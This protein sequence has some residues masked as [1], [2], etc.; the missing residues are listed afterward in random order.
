MSIIFFYSKGED[1]QWTI[2]LPLMYW[3]LRSGNILETLTREAHLSHLISS[4]LISL[5]RFVSRL[6]PQPLRLTDFVAG[7]NLVAWKICRFCRLSLICK[8]I[9]WIKRSNHKIVK[10]PQNLYATLWN[11]KELLTVTNFLIT[12]LNRNNFE[13]YLLFSAEITKKLM[14]SFFFLSTGGNDNGADQEHWTN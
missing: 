7:L 4:D 2:T 8:K 1:W 12:R 5:L 6:T 11:W 10:F 14:K 13:G 3:T 9:R